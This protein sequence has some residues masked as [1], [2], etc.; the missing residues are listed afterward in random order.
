MRNIKFV[1]EHKFMLK[2]LQEQYLYVQEFENGYWLIGTEDNLQLYHTTKDIIFDD[3]IPNVDKII[4][5][6]W[7]GKN[8]KRWR[9]EFN[10]F[11]KEAKLIKKDLNKFCLC[12][13]PSEEMYQPT[14][15]SDEN[16]GFYY[17]DGEVIKFNFNRFNQEEYDEEQ[18]K[19][20]KRR[21]DK[22]E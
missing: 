11:I 21:E 15:L 19:K 17:P 9:L 6:G 4:F 7:I 12:Y 8:N 2:A 1:Q 22:N 18:K 20:A 16:T 14:F 5:R 3:F 10:E 13:L